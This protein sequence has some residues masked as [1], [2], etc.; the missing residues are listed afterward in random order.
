MLLPIFVDYGVHNHKAVETPRLREALKFKLGV[1]ST[2]NSLDHVEADD[3]LMA[4][5]D[6]SVKDMEAAA[7][8]WAAEL[9][10]VP[11]F[12]LKVVTDIVDG[13][14]ATEEEFVANFAMAQ[15]RL[16]EAVPA[17]LDYVLGRSLEEL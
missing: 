5:N 2:G 9:Y 16:Q 11:Y 14:H 13:A 12:A 4:A 7:V 1:V 17:T 8:A 15:R 10:S 6:A 3:A